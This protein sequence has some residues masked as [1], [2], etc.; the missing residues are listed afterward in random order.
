[1]AFPITEITMD[2][3]DSE[4][5]DSTSRYSDSKAIYWGPKNILTLKTYKRKPPIKDESDR[6]MVIKM[7]HAYRPDLV[8][9]EVYG[10][11]EFWYKIME[12]NLM[13]DI[14]EFKTGVNIRIPVNAYL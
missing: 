11:P 5:V 2:L 3:V 12:L 8:S 1:M 6:F 13:S 7:G 9:Q 4:L 10:T 14:M